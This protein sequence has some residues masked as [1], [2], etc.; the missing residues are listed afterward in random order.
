MDQPKQFN[1]PL[2]LF[3][4]CGHYQQTV[5][6]VLQYQSLTTYKSGPYITLLVKYTVTLLFIINWKYHM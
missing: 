2:I 4:V 6:S 1:S 3:R 5:F